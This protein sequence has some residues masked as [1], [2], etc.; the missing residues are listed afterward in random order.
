MEKLVL[1]IHSVSALVIIGLILLQ[2]GKGAAA[3]ASFGSGASQTVFGSDGGGSFFSRATAIFA[4]IF[5]CT[6]LGL[7]MIAKSHSKV[8]A[9]A[10]PVPAAQQAPASQAADVPASAPAAQAPAAAGDVPVTTPEQK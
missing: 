10:I 3:G 7:A 1:V 2:Q 4:A 8:S 5:F 6:S 9:S